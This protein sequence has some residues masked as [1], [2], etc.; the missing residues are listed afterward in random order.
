MQYM[1]QNRVA[2]TQVITYETPY[3]DLGEA[4]MLT[5]DLTIYSIT[6]TSPQV[7]VTLQSSDDLQTWTDI[8]SSVNGSSTGSTYGAVQALTNPY[9]K[10]GRVKIAITGTDPTANFSVA[11]NTFPSS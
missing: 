1:M 8:G 2:Q 10:Y 4:P 7:S 5:L 11:L 6:G 9:G 3:V